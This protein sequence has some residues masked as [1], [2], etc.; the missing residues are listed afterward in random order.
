MHTV[1]YHR[2]VYEYI[3][4]FS[5]E[6]DQV[7]EVHWEMTVEFLSRNAGICQISAV[8]NQTGLYD[9]AAK[10]KPLFQKKKKWNKAMRK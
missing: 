4:L 7:P 5:Q 2:T 3:V 9:W 10:L 6:G 8:F 1:I